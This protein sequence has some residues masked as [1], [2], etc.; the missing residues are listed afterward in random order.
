MSTGRI[1][2]ARTVRDRLDLTATAHVE[3]S[4]LG[5]GEA[6]LGAANIVDLL[7]VLAEDEDHLVPLLTDTAY[8]QADLLSRLPIPALRRLAE[9]SDVPGE[10][11][12]AFARLAWAR[13]YALGRTVDP[14]LDRLM[15]SLNPDIT[16]HWLSRP[17]RSIRPHDRLA[18]Q[19]VL[20]TPAL[21]V[22][23]DRWSRHRATPNSAAEGIDVGR[24]DHNMNNGDNWWCPLAADRDAGADGA[25]AL[26]LGGIETVL[27]PA[28]SPIPDSW[29]KARGTIL[30]PLR[31]ASFLLRSPDAAE[32]AALSRIP[33]A[34]QLLTNRAIA[35]VEHPGLLGRRTGLA[36]T[37]AASIIATRWGCRIE[38]GNGTF[39]RAAFHLLHAHFPDS[40]AAKRTKYWYN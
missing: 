28:D 26:T 23:I 6:A 35:W 37:L 40:E 24:M 15:R 19:D 18:L 29:T 21:N 36:D 39:S 13:T 8:E 4:S 11:R 10:D 31:S 14:Q 16:A 12:S 3:A 32:E 2:E 25:L 5:G 7:L 38:A 27:L 33:S 30:R 34:P 17:G 22:A 9:R 1:A 20:A